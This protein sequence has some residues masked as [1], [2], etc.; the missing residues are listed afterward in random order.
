MR[1]K[2]V[3]QDT[4]VDFFR[5][6]RYTFGASMLAMVLSVVA[7]F[8]MGLNFGIDFKGGTTIRTEAVQPVDI[9]AYRAALE[10]LGFGDVSITEVFDP[11]FGPDRNV[12]MVRIQAQEGQEA[13]TPEQLESIRAALQVLDPTLTFASV[14][15]VGPKVS[16]ELVQSAVISVLLALGAVLFYIW[17]R[18]EWQ[19]SVGAVAALVH[20]VVLT[21]GLFAA[22]QI[23]FDLAIIAALLTIVGYSLNDTVVVFDRVRENLIKFKK[24]P[25]REVLN[26]SIN[27][28]LSRT[29]MTSVTTLIALI[30]L[31]VLGGDVIRGFVFAMIWGIIVGTYSSVFVASVVLYRFG[32]K[33]DWTK[34]AGDTAGTQFGV[35]EG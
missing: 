23:R 35:K 22:L 19:F 3:P 18:F 10:P 6:W 20:D 34:A 26:L 21:I 17:L 1:L 7:F 13:K 32:V 33:R 29:V 16:G 30:S 25:L 24:R 2:L 5:F 28:T 15:S 31:F 27:D 12:A 8:M 9:G 11:S 4:S 14:D